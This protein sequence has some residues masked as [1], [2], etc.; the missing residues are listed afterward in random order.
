MTLNALTWATRNSGTRG[1]QNARSTRR[2]MKKQQFRGHSDRPGR[3]V[4][5]TAD[6]G[7]G[8]ESSE[9]CAMSVAECAGPPLQPSSAAPVESR[10]GGLSDQ[11]GRM[12]WTP[13][14]GLHERD[15]ALCRHRFDI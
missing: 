1:G 3:T 11:S 13:S 6:L 7:L 9:T 14:Q 2:E 5:K 8:Q 15:V 10:Q 12:P 4:C